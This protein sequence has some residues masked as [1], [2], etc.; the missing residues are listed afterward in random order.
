MT[1]RGKTDTEHTNNAGMQERAAWANCRDATVTQ[2]VH[3]IVI[4]L[5]VVKRDSRNTHRSHR[6]KDWSQAVVTR[7]GV[8]W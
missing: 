6:I 1:F 5:Q 8:A 7:H 2:T 4:G 3:I